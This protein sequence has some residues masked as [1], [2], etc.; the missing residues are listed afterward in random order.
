MKRILLLFLAVSAICTSLYSQYSRGE[1][2][3]QF[4]SSESFVLFEE[5]QEALPG[6]ELNFRVD[7]TNYNIRYRIGQC[8]LNIPG[9][10]HEAI[11]FLEAAVKEISPKYREGKFTEKRAPYDAYYYLANAYR[12]NNQLE[13]AIATYELFKQNLDPKVYDIDVVNLQIESCRNALEVMK[14]PGFMKKTNLGDVINDRLNEVNPVVS[15]DE[16]VMVYNRTGGFQDALLYTRKVNGKWSQPVNIIPDLGLGF[17]EGNYATSLSDDGSELYVYRSGDDYD[18]NIYVTRRVGEKWSTL[19]KLNNNINTKFW[20]S[21][22]SVSHDGRK[23]YFTSNRKGTLGGL[24]IYVSEKD[25]TG[26]WGPAKNL[27]ASINTRYNEETPFLG[28]DDKTLFFSSRGHF[29]IGGHDIFYSTL[30]EE[31]NWTLPINTG[32]PLNSTDDDVFFNPTKDGYSA[33]FSILDTTGYGLADIYYIEIFSNKHP[34]N[35]IIRGIARV[36]DLMK[37]FRDSI[38]ISALTIKDPDTKVIIYTDPVTGEYKFELPQG[39]YSIAFEARGAEKLTTDLELKL[40][41]PDD[42]ILIP[43]VELPRNDFIADMSVGVNQNISVSTGDTISIPLRVEPGSVLTVEHW[44]NDS[45]VHTRKFNISSPDFSY[46]MV[47][48]VGI[49]RLVFILE[50]RFGNKTT[51]EIFITREKAVTP[52]PVVRP[53]YKRIIAEKQ[54]EAFTDMLEKRSED[55]L[56]GMI[57]KSGIGKK[58]F[59]SIDDVLAYLKEEALKNKLDQSEIDKLAL[60]VAVEDNILSQA[61][62]DLLAANADGL[63]KEILSGLNIYESGLKTWNDLKEYVFSKS[64]GRILPEDLDKLAAEILAVTDPGIDKI[65]NNI[66]EYGKNYEK[67]KAVT[68]AVAA[69]DEQKLRTAGEWLKKF[70]NEALGFGLSE[71]DL[72]GIIKAI[73]SLPGENVE[74][75]ITE[76][77]KYSEKQAADYLR[78]IDLDKNRIKTPEDL[79]LHLIEGRDLGFFSEDIL[80][81]ALSKMIIGRDIPSDVIA[82]HLTAGG[83]RRLLALWI[84]LGAGLIF[85]FIIFW[86]RK[87]KKDNSEKDQ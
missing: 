45:L 52:Q 21:H 29:N 80:F 81:S 78:E 1:L 53:E 3:D 31:G 5:Y 86:R 4:Y 68:D 71:S 20:E 82:S 59:S 22:A 30:D 19:E 8:L 54:I 13:K 28:E 73:S 48:Y 66:L 26:N 43:P 65:R 76:L 10:K 36:K 9:R 49:N 42:S 57:Q 64:G 62:V 35:F 24:D 46:K 55:E 61:A 11:S 47:P 14:T 83:E 77:I 69:T 2:K 75:Y 27:G 70:F 32:Y 40:D 12:I 17:E 60:K 63:L 85:I 6:Y 56:S 16:T 44:L 39:E 67:G 37:N 25:S 23:L 58:D 15:G 7:P 51:S 87:K 84:L 33:F 74:D 79:I 34:R 38:K 72:A 18:G 41:H 50:D